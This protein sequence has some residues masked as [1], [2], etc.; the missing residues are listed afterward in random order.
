MPKKNLIIVATIGIIIVVG[1]IIFN[2][3]KPDENFVLNFIKD[4]PDRS[5]IQLFRNDELIAERNPNK[6]MPLASTV[7]VT[8]AI[9]YAVQ[10]SENKIDPNEEISIDELSKFYV[11]GTDGGAQS[12]WLESVKDKIKDNK[13]PIREIAKGMLFFSSNANTEWLT[14]KL[15]LDNI[16]KRIKSLGIKDHTR[17]YYIVSSLFV[18]KEKF[19]SLKGEELAQKIRFLSLDDYIKTTNTIHSKL[20]NDADYKNDIGDFGTDIQ[21]VW[22]DNLPSSTVK[23]YAGIMK[24]IN[25]RTYFDPKTR[26]YLDEVMKELTE[27][28][29]IKKQFK[30]AGMK[31]GSTPFVSTKALYAT[32]KEGNTTEL[33]YFF[34][35]LN[36][37]EGTKLRVSKSKF[38]LKILTSE[39]FRNKIKSE[40]KN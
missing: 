27:D 16:N 39:E 11:P 38:E 23:E 40:L 29:A 5:A 3:F 19:P 15:G 4:N 17:F 9:E 25:S 7:K 31:G 35:D 24:K 20:L 33:A 2:Y 30:H 34:N 21:K 37:L 26:K 13:I 28:P 10:A 8:V 18:G 1:A 22:S 32:D 36:F 12:K 6:L 14:D